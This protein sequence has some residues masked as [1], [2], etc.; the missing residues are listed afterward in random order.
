MPHVLWEYQGWQKPV[1]VTEV[2]DGKEVQVFKEFETIT[3]GTLSADEYD[4]MITDLTN[5]MAYLADPK[6]HER[7][8]IGMFVLLFLFGLLALTWLLK[9]DYWKDIQ[10]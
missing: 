5:F 1:Y 4:D 7:H 10:K 8:R 2:Q 9:Q 6:K 3:E